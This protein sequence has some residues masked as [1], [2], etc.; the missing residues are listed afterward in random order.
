MAVVSHIWLYP[1]KSL[2]G[3]SVERV[4]VLPS[5]ALEGD[6]EFAI[7]DARDRY[8]NAKRT[9]SIHQIRARFDLN[10]RSV[11]LGVR[12]QPERQTFHL[13]TE[14]SHL[15]QWF[16]NFFQQPARL[17]R[18]PNLGFPDD[19]KRPGPTVI[20]ERSLSEIAD[21]YPELNV[22]HVRQ[23]FRANIEI[24]DVP[25]FW[26]DSLVDPGDR[27]IPF[28]VGDVDFEGLNPCDRCVVPTRDPATGEVYPQ[29]RKIF[30]ERRRSTAP[31]WAQ[32][33]RFKHLYRL[34][35]NTRMSPH[36][37]GGLIHCQDEVV[38]Y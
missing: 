23:R 28:R 25:A 17:V 2:D 5:G 35:T 31:K 4:R 36:H 30:M 24:G 7:V 26:E 15:E 16:S 27:P 11:E 12:D 14:R 38:L 6:R 9:A 3:I 1:I 20:A 37:S 33:D 8:I 19:M 10:A 13:D 32:S 21:W 34:T 22:E 29:F 18:D